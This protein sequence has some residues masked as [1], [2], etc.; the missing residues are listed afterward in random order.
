MKVTYDVTTPSIDDYV[1]PERELGS[2]QRTFVDRDE[3]NSFKN[4]SRTSASIF[5]ASSDS[6][7]AILAVFN[8]LKSKSP[9][10]AMLEI[11][12]A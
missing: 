9:T 4:L 6:P 11:T 10:L 7:E 1:Q 12:S 3:W 5:V 8:Y 2:A